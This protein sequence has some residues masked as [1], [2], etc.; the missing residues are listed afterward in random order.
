MKSKSF[1]VLLASCAAFALA[2]AAPAIG[3]AA[4]PY[5]FRWK[6]PIEGFTVADP[7]EVHVSND[8]EAEIGVPWS[9]QATASG[10]NG[11]PYSFSLDPA[12][13][14]LSIN[15]ASGL[16][17]GTPVAPA[18][19]HTFTVTA[20]DGELSGSEA[21]SVEV[22]AP[23]TAP[24]VVISAVEGEEVSSSVAA[25]GGRAPYSHAWDNESPAHPS[26]LT[27]DPDTGALTGTAANGSWTPKIVV[28]DSRGRTAEVDVLVDV[29]AGLVAGSELQI[30]AEA[31]DAVSELPS[32][33]GGTPPYSY[34]W[35]SPAGERPAWLALNPGTGELSGVAAEGNWSPVIRVED[36]HGR[37]AEIEVSVVVTLPFEVPEGIDVEGAE[38]DLIDEA[39]QVS[40]GTPPYSFSWDPDGGTPPDW[41][42]LDPA[43]GA[44]TGEAEEGSWSAIV[45]VEDSA[46]RSSGYP[47]T[48][49]I[50]AV[51][52][53]DRPQLITYGGV[54]ANRARD[55]VMTNDGHFVVVGGVNI[56]GDP[57]GFVAKIGLD[58]SIPWSKS[59]ATTAGRE[60]YNSG[61]AVAAD[62][63][64]YVVGYKGSGGNQHGTL[65]SKFSPS[66]E[67]LWSRYISPQVSSGNTKVTVGSDGNVYLVSNGSN[68][69]VGKYNGSTGATIWGKEYATGDYKVLTVNDLHFGSD[70]YLYLAGSYSQRFMWL[71]ID[72]SNGNI[73][74]GRRPNA[75]NFDL[76]SE[77]FAVVTDADGTTYVGGRVF[78]GGW[79]MFLL[80]VTWNTPT[81]T[82][83]NG[84]YL[85]LT[86]SLGLEIRGM[87]IGPDGKLYLAGTTSDVYKSFIA[88]IS[89]NLEP[90]RLNV[91]TSSSG[92]PFF[93]NF[94]LAGDEVVAVGSIG[95]KAAILRLPLHEG[96]EL[97][98]GFTYT[99]APWSSNARASFH[100]YM[101]AN[102]TPLG[103]STVT[104]QNYVDNAGITF[105]DLAPAE[106]E[107]LDE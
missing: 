21:F 49:E 91:F 89:K 82:N 74:A 44:L 15:P 66:G 40:G 5:T 38:G 106:N 72:A 3:Q 24:S 58:G 59:M 29:A 19:S 76:S 81:Q 4:D 97:S 13:T 101:W 67:R 26:W 36:A 64:Y 7:V 51:S 104:Y 35:V 107:Y 98:G 77:A 63:S 16:L 9:L 95:S 23:L 22:V 60:D 79:K 17:T 41:L 68:F 70:G 65:F 102:Y 10:G 27:L 80:K 90:E 50:G 6:M 87:E 96:A 31:G 75:T 78:N 99:S 46:G 48:V 103:G 71:K 37:Q 93:Y 14:W 30:I 54:S 69:H 2:A 25:S 32:V 45:R 105:S 39:P 88:R 42:T 61:V 94:A 56:D 52:G 53:A 43:T 28:T 57:D 20:T 18:G 62:G 85:S 47:V 73:V 86:D 100:Q 83:G 92:T 34:S 1:Y 11:G 8:P 84:E 12:S 33:S 55:V